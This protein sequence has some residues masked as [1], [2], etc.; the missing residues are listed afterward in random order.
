MPRQFTFNPWQHGDGDRR[1]WGFLN[2]ELDNLYTLLSTGT[3]ITITQANSFA[4][5][6]AVGISG[7]S[8][9]LA[10]ADGAAPID[11]L[12]LVASATAS[13]FEIVF[14]GPMSWGSH[15]LGV[16]TKYYLDPTTAGDVTST[17]PFPPDKT[18]HVLIPIDSSTVL[19]QVR[20]AI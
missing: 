2:D 7:G 10:V 20:E 9:V 3:P 4:T 19:V 18:Q 6:D 13:D 12:G 15:G 5:G 16:G 11:C 17:Q 8:W 1:Q 14:S